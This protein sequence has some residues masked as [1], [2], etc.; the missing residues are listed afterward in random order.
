MVK[1]NLFFELIKM[2]TNSSVSLSFKPTPTDWDE[3]FRLAK[4]HALVGV[5]FAVVEQ[6][7]KE[8]YPPRKL[9]MEWFLSAERVKT[10]NQ[11]VD[12]DSIKMC[13]VVRKDG[14][15]GMVLK[16]QSVGTYYPNPLL[17]MPGDIDFWI[18]G[19]PKKVLGYLKSK[20]KVKNVVYT[21][22]E[23]NVPVKTEVEIHH[24]ISFFYN[25]LY[26]YRFKKFLKG[27][28]ALFDNRVQLKCGGYIYAP[29][30]EFNRF[31]ILLHIY[32]HL[33]AEGIGLRQLMDYYYVLRQGG[34][35]DSWLRT[36]DLL[37]KT[38]MCHFAEG[39]MWVMQEVFGLED[40]FLLCSPNKRHGEKLL[41]EIMLAGNFG[42]FDN[43]INWEH[44]K[45][46]LPRVWGSVKRKFRFFY[47]YPLELVFDIP[48][49][50]GMYLWKFII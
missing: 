33:L 14:Q 3:A 50:L 16:G 22:S 43:R 48:A 6:L 23:C 28:Y 15:R 34:T 49:R 19:G 26:H 24:N 30:V 4:M 32:R 13:D 39:I 7:P 1:N 9:M 20:G 36:Q 29:T 8:F 37:K 25:P 38:G 11:I 27:Q 47:D 40:S 41:N 45:R 35:K 31:Y 44:R 21:H 18:E 2:G 10:M 17:R 46:L 42:K 5:V 12:S